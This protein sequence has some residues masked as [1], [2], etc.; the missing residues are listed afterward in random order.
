VFSSARI[1]DIDQ[2]VVGEL[3]IPATIREAAELKRI[4]IGNSSKWWT[5]W[6]NS[7]DEKMHALVKDVPGL[8]KA[9]TTSG[10]A[11]MMESTKYK[12]AMQ[13]IPTYWAGL[14]FLT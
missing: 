13:G 4:A 3:N 12:M 2:Y 11:K 9:D 5:D 1:K 10:L 6:D 14:L 8:P 7:I